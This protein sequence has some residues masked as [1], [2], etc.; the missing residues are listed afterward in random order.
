[1]EIYLLGMFPS[2]TN[3]QWMFRSAS[4]FNGDISNWDVDRYEYV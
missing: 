3:M 4:V 1:M 2:V